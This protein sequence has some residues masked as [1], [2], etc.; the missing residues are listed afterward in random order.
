MKVK[1][2]TQ[3]E[4]IKQKGYYPMLIGGEWV[5]S[6]TG[7]W[8]DVTNPADGQLLARVP[9]GNVEDVNVA[10]EAAQAA[11]TAWK[12]TPPLQRG[13]MLLKI[14]DLLEERMDYLA[15]VDAI[16]SG[17]PFSAMKQDIVAAA[18]LIRYFAGLALE[19]KGDTLPPSGPMLHSTIREP[20]GVVARIIPFNHPLMFAAGKIAAPLATGNT[21]VL[22]PADQTP[23][24]PLIFGE[25][26]SE[27]LPPGV[28]NIITGGGANVGDA[29][30]RHPLV[31]R[32]AFTGGGATGKKVLATAAEQFKVVSLELGGKNPML[33]FPDV[34]LNE[35]VQSAVKGMNFDVSQGQSCGSTSRIFVHFRSPFE[36]GGGFC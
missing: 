32:I 34:N 2:T 36:E 25:L 29:L 9:D 17:N 13:R 8:M 24:S 28:L 1:N 15:M 6:K 11:F 5:E 19:M 14:A 20:Y 33:V 26:A 22:K 31:R 30:V 27:V 23:I 21:V 16:D 35:A 18:R 12:K 10:V 7:Q 3:L 4:E